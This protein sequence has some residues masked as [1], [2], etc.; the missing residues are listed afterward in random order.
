MNLH[1]KLTITLLA[2]LIVVVTIAQYLQHRS[3]MELISSLSESNLTLLREREE[4]H[5]LNVFRSV[6][7]AVP[8]RPFC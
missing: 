2:G 7:R 5:A 8:W 6:E 3:S 4:G 1:T